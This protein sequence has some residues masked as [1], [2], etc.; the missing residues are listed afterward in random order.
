MEMGKAGPESE[1]HDGLDEELDKRLVALLGVVVG[2]GA[3]VL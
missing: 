1:L 2:M 3:V